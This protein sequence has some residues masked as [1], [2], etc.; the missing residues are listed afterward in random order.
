MHQRLI[1]LL[2]LTLIAG[3]GR[4]CCHTS[5]A[6]KGEVLSCCDVPDRAQLFAHFADDAPPAGTWP[7]FGGTPERNMV[8]AVDKNIP[9]EWSVEEGKRKNIKWVADLGNKC[10]G[11]PVVADGKV[12]VGTNNANPRDPKV[13]GSKAVLMAFNEADGKFLWQITHD[14]PADDLFNMAIPVGLCSTPVV[15]GQRVY[16]VTPDCQ[17]I[18]A[19]TA[20]KVQWHYNMMKELKVV[21]FHCGNCSPLVGGDLVVVITGNGVNEEGKVPSPKAPS[22]AAFN[23]TTGKLVWQSDLPGANII[24]GQWS[25]PTLATVNGKQQVI[26]PGGDAYLYGLEFDSGKLIWKFNCQPVRPAKSDDRTPQL[27]MISTA[28]AHD[29]KAYIGL[30]V[31][32]DTGTSPP[33]SYFLCVDITKTGDVSPKTLDHKD[34][35]NKDSAL[36]WSYGGKIEPVP[37]K[38]RRVRFGTTI[39]T[40]A[41][42]DGL[43]YIAEE[44]GYLYCFDAKS[45]E[46]YWEH[47]FKSGIWGSPY[48]VDGKVYIGT[49]DSEVVVFAH[50]KKLQLL[51]KNDMNDIVHSTPV[52]AGGVMYVATRAKLYAISAK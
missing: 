18:C 50:G 20:G 48:C 27:Y 46:K 32:P 25:N 26:F 6:A 35:K 14:Y 45:G 34:A 8:N 12:F 42:H 38:G 37:K 9:T 31:A 2:F 23:K 3:C 39:S 29:G 21:P 28:V 1:V 47:D 52:V 16:Y 43:V 30:G 44:R 19:D 15:E 17:V 41:I 11:G 5:T 7:M 33:F 13:K 49:E 36:V 40:C 51:A 4:D 24:E 10:Y 22:F